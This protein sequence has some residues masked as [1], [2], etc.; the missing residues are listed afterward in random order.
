MLGAIALP[1]HSRWPPVF[2]TARVLGSREVSLIEQI[3]KAIC[4]IL[5][6]SVAFPS[7]QPADTI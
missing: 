7:A 2:Y 1:A 5:Y 6:A 3:S 4:V